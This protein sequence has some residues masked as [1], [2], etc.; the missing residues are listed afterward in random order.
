MPAS[1]AGLA[2]GVGPLRRLTPAGTLRARA[3]LPSVILSC[4]L[5]T[6]AFFGADTFVPYALHDGRGA[7]LLA[8]SV[9]VTL[10]TVMWTAG[11]WM[12]DR[13]INITGEALFIRWAYAVMVPALVIVA[14][15][16]ASGTLP[17]WVIH[18]GWAL[19]G[20]AM[21][22]GY[23][24][25]SQLALRCA[26]DQQYGATTAS[27][28]LLDNLGVALGTG[29]TGVIVTLGHDVGWD[30]GPAVAT[31]IIPMAAVAALGLVVSTRLPSRRNPGRRR[32]QPN[33]PQ[34]SD[35]MLPSSTAARS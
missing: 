22:L 15:G 26:P 8:G 24:A 32:G 31:A 16:A 29:A 1:V 13:W 11:V 12:Q 33:E 35:P 3:G 5:L 4:G 27:L 28:Q 34:G 18:V 25:H 23:A 2:I 21:G 14:V 20:L 30:P 9:A 17:F 19:G 10:A 7:S 6:F